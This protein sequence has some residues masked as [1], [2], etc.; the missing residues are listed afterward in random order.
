MISE[1]ARY[2]RATPIANR[3][4][5]FKLI[6]RTLPAKSLDHRFPAVDSKSAG[7]NGNVQWLPTGR[8]VEIR[9]HQ[10]PLLELLRV[11]NRVWVLGRA[12]HER[13]VTL[14]WSRRF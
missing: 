4:Y 1:S 14:T 6:A 5:F 9:T 12:V 11:W 7:R 2:K 13:A 3:R 10:I 8:Q